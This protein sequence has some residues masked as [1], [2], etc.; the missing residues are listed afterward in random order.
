MDLEREIV[1]SPIG[2][3]FKGLMD[4]QPHDLPGAVVKNTISL[5]PFQT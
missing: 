5:H 2:K 3:A 4:S 1:V